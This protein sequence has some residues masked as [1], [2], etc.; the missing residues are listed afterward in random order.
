M[1][2]PLELDLRDPVKMVAIKYVNEQEYLKLGGEP[3]DLSS[4]ADCSDDRALAGS[5]AAAVKAQARGMY[6]GAF[7]DPICGYNWRELLQKPRDAADSRESWEVRMKAAEEQ[8]RQESII[9]LRQ[10]VKDFADW[11]KAQG[12]I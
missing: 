8:A 3:P 1:V 6:F 12:V 10:Q 7:Y 5:V 11:L 2:A 9:L 4:S